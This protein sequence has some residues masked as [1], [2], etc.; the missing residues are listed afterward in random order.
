MEWIPF[1]IGLA[2]SGLIVGALARLILPGPETIGV[3]GTIL[4]GL[5]G[6]FIGGVVGRLLF[7]ATGWF[8]SFV[9]AVAGAV[10]LILPFCAYRYRTR[11]R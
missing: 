10:L 1:L 7:G 4:A 2:I 6:A 5:G 3:L 9:L 8:L 11:I